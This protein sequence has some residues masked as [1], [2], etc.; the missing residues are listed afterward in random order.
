MQ[1]WA[2]PAGA[3]PGEVSVGGQDV[4]G[5]AA[6]I[7][8]PGCGH[9]VVLSPVPSSLLLPQIRTGPQ[10]RTAWGL[11]GNGSTLM[12]RCVRGDAD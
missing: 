5:K 4:C 11:E 8:G 6:V 9:P 10:L 7:P 12:L 1:A 3:L 2:C